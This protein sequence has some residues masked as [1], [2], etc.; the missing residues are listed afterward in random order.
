MYVLR[1]ERRGLAFN[2]DALSNAKVTPLKRK[3]M[4]P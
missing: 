3:D 4:A 2:K 1:H